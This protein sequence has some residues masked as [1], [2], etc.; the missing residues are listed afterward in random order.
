MTWPASDVPPTGLAAGT[1]TPP[2]SAF[3]AG[4]QAFNQMRA[5]VT[6]CMQSARGSADAADARTQLDVPSRAGGN[7]TGTW[8][9]DISGNAAT[10]TTATNCSRSVSGA[11]LA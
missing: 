3:L 2:R 6:T 5:H 4:A 7:A 11:G 9:I 10:A 8:G 1:D